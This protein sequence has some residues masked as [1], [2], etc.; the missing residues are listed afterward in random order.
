MLSGTIE[1]FHHDGFLHFTS[2]RRD[3]G[4]RVLAEWFGN[5]LV[6]KTQLMQIICAINS[7]SQTP[8]AAGWIWGGNGHNVFVSGES[9]YVENEYV[10]TDRVFMTRTQLLT[11]L[12][13]FRSFF[14]S[15][16]RDEFFKP[17]P[18]EVSFEA[19]GEMAEM[20]YRELT[21]L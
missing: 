18:I 12:E 2:H 14:V 21:G 11:A 3:L 20:K 16:R 7:A 8:D 19:E 4:G 15:E 17:V 1:P 13:T 5:D 10:A 9:I 6:S